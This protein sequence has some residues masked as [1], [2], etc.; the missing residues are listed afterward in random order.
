M[1]GDQEAFE[2]GMDGIDWSKKS[3]WQDERPVCPLCKG[4]AEEGTCPVCG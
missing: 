4:E 3:G 1:P 2:N